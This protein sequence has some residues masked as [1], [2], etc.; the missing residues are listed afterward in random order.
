MQS[1]VAPGGR[2]GA[3]TKGEE[4]GKGVLE[5]EVGKGVRGGVEGAGEV[6][7]GP[8]EIPTTYIWKASSQLVHSTVRAKDFERSLDF[9]RALKE[10]DG[11]PRKI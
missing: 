5:L 7:L 1:P 9:L 8:S 3:V 2:A 10:S 4:D 6:E 11:P